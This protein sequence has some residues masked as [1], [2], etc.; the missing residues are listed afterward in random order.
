MSSGIKSQRSW[1]LALVGL[2]FFAVGAGFLLLSVIPILYDGI[3]MQSWHSTQ[4]TLLSAKAIVSSSGDSTT[5]GVKASYSYTVNGHTYENSRVAIDGSNDNIGDFQQDLGRYLERYHG[6][7]EP[8]MVWYD[9]ASPADS[10][11]NRKIRWGLLGFKLLFVLAFGGSGLGLI[12]FALRGKRNKV[13]ARRRWTRFPAPSAAM[14]AAKFWSIC[15]SSPRS[16]TKSH[17]ATCTAT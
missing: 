12:I 2:P 1:L 5:Y 11:L 15:A 7:R 16:P 8:V 3:R 14:L 17:S 9:P 10:I 13:S 6:N 4:A